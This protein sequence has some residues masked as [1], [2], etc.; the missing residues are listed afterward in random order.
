[1]KI[2]I[3]MFLLSIIAIIGIGLT[4]AK[5]PTGPNTINYEDPRGLITS[6]LVLILLALPAFI[7]TIFSHIIPRIISG[8]LQIC[9]LVMWVPLAIIAFVIGPLP[10]AFMVTLACIIIIISAIVTFSVGSSK[11]SQTASKHI[12]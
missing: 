9:S 6:L 3:S 4:C 11:S 10:L 5:Y 2:R 8:I 7:L 1:M 12:H